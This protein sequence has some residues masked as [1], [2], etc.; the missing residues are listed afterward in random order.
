M[1]K[2]LRIWT[3]LMPGQQFVPHPD[4]WA[5]SSIFDK[6]MAV[7][8]GVVCWWSGSGD[9]LC[10]LHPMDSCHRIIIATNLVTYLWC[11]HRGF[12]ALLTQVSGWH[13]IKTFPLHLSAILET[14]STL[15]YC[16]LENVRHG[17]GRLAEEKKIC[18]AVRFLWFYGQYPP[19]TVNQSVQKTHQCCF[20]S[21]QGVAPVWSSLSRP[22]GCWVLTQPASSNLP[23]KT[24]RALN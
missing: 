21:L 6:I 5:V 9:S 22:P 15:I 8:K 19:L 3:C 4:F 7:Q 20:C 23:G 1:H 2:W 13:L 17:S 16:H 14:L 10:S 12:M 18:I 11:Y 24:P